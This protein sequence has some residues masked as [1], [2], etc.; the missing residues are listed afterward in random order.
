[1]TSINSLNEWWGRSLGEQLEMNI[2]Q[3]YTVRTQ[4]CSILGY[5]ACRINLPFE[6]VANIDCYSLINAKYKWLIN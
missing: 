2:A 1:M 5:K 4:M 3:H 6:V